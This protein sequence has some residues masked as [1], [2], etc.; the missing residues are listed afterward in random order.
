M[1]AQANTV[2]PVCIVM[3]TFSTV[4]ALGMTP[5]LLDLYCRGFSNL[6]N[7]V[8][9]AGIMVTLVMS[10]MSCTI[11]ILINYFRPVYSR[12]ITRAGLSITIVVVGIRTTVS[13]G[14]G[15]SILTVLSPSMM[16]IS[17]LMPLIGFALRYIISFIFRADG[18]EVTTAEKPKKDIWSTVITIFCFRGRRTITMETGCQNVQ[19]CAT[20]LKTAFQL[21]EATVLI[22]L[23][24]DSSTNR[25]A[26]QPGCQRRRTDN[27][28]A[29]EV[30][31]S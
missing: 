3:T 29:D 9:Y 30:P 12:T 19:L 16:A 22:L 5:L 10:L 8:P 20:V 18:K 31:Q 15:T 1:Y 26:G 7:A 27:E 14:A 25:K 4:L 24:P 21:M 6:E 13:I 11:G 23:S 17:T 2:T 28:T